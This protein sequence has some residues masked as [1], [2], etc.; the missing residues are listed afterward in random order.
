LRRKADGDVNGEWK[1]TSDAS[2]S[3]D[4]SPHERRGYGLAG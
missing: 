3:V 2:S 4:Y 1:T